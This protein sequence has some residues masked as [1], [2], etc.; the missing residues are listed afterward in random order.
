VRLRPAL[1]TG[2]TILLVAALAGCGGSDSS[3]NGVAAKS[4]AQ[5]LAASKAA[6]DGAS[7]VHVSGSVVSA[8]T[9]L[10]LNLTLAAGRGGRG[11]ISTNGLS[12]ELIQVD[13]TA[14]I[15]GSP[16][17]YRHFAGAAAAQLL[18]GRWLKAP[19]STGELAPISS[20]TDMRKLVDSGL[21]SHETLVKGA[22]TT[23]D[24]RPVIALKY[25]S[26]GGT[27]YVATTGTPYPIEIEK[28]GS[29][30][31]KISFE[32]WNVPV[33]IAAPANAI[34][35]NQLKSGH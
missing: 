5:I 12:F 2:S 33:A 26:K 35:I 9:P 30:G 20:L 6:A 3:G 17:F 1:S 11:Q 34:D 31:G 16:T 24:G 8:G 7:S 14:Y 23:I 18:Q 19:A 27:L 22:T 4:P 15:D 28:A 25:A 13:G 10:A 32:H 21:G 29:E